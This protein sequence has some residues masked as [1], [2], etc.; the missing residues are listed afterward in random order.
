[1]S[2]LFGGGVDQSAPAASSLQLQTSN[3]GRAITIVYGTTRIS[4]NLIWY[5][6]FKSIPQTQ[7]IG[8]KGGSPTQTTYTY[9]VAA[10][11]ALCEGVLGSITEKTTKQWSYRG[12][13]GPTTYTYTGVR[14]IYADQSKFTPATLNMS[15]FTGT[16]AQT[17]F[18]YVTTNHP[19]E[20]LNYKNLAYVASGAY[21]L[22][23]NSSLPQHL[24]EVIG[25]LANA[26]NTGIYDA[27]PYDIAYD[28]LTNTVY[29]AS[30]PSGKLADATGNYL[31]AAGIWLSPSYDTPAP[32]ADALKQIAML[33]NC[34]WVWSGGVLR[35][36]PYGLDAITGGPGVTLAQGSTP[37]G[38]LTYTP[39]SIATPVY[40]L[41]DGDFLDQGGDD[42]VIVTRSPQTFAYN[43]VQVKYRNRFADYADT[44]AEAKDLASIEAFGLLPMPDVSAPEICDGIVARTVA[45]M[46]L[47]RAQ[48]IR[49]TYKF[50]VGYRYILLDP[51]DLVTLTESTGSGLNNQV[52]RITQITENDDGSL[53]IEAEDVVGNVTTVA[54]YPE[55][56][57]SGYLVNY[58]DPAP[59]VNAPIIFD[60]PGRKT[61]TGYELWIAV[62]Q[63]ASPWG[64]CNVWVSLD[65]STYKMVGSQRGSARY[66]T[67]TSSV[68]AGADPD[69]VNSIPVDLTTSGGTLTA[70]STSDADNANTLCWLDGELISYSAATL[71]AANKYT[72][73][74]Y[75]R[76]GVY[77]TTIKAHSNG[78]G[79][80]RLDTGIFAYPYDPSLVGKTV[81]V[82]LQSVNS[83]GA[84]VQDISTCTPYSYTI[85]GPIG[86]P[87]AA[88][89]LTAVA[90]I[91]G[92]QL[93]W[94]ASPSPDLAEYEI[95]SGTTW[96]SATYIGRSRTTSYLLPPPV[97]GTS[98]WLVAAMNKAGAYSPAISVTLTVS[99]PS[100][101]TVTAQVVDNTVLL[102]WTASTGTLPVA[103]YQ[104]RKGATYAGATIIGTKSG[105]FTTV[106][107][108]A[109]G[110]YTYWV[111]AIDG[112]GNFG[113][114]ASVTTVVNQPPDYVL[115]ALLTSTFT[116]TKTNAV[117]DING[118][119]VLPVDTTTQ[120]QTHFTGNSWA[121]PQDQVTAG[122]TLFIEPASATGSYVEVFDLGAVI[123]AAKITVAWAETD[124]GTPGVSCVIATSPDNI[125]YTPFGAGT[126]VY[127]TNYRYVKVTLS[128]TSSAGLDL[129]TIS[130][131]T[132]RVDAKLKNDAGSGTVTVAASGASVSFGASFAAVTSITVTPA[133]TSGAGS[134]IIPVVSFAGGANPT[135]FTVY[136][137]TTAGA[138]TTGSFNWSAKGY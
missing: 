79:F 96:A 1:M 14:T 108:T 17:A 54:Q 72:L 5:S 53:D 37:L 50:R 60:A 116:G 13:S 23:S 137:Y 118:T 88:S 119:L 111:V 28:L 52:V 63:P 55:Q 2:G 99:A 87:A 34:E 61:A 27:R 84:G 9:Q 8:G 67:L 75:I 46:L 32:V 89:A 102:F 15:V 73:G 100:A 74:T 115:K 101:P 41:T 62:G 26:G 48:Y 110:T 21:N 98:S 124:V 69:T 68:A 82:K 120:Y 25:I 78:A 30:W 94:T 56:L 106:Q 18:S 20:A 103:T 7:S 3:Y 38:T 33:S 70:G 86:A 44:V 112:A 65:G 66:G 131:L 51:M 130:N 90:A 80:A 95:R 49:N 135:S 35:F 105:L 31:Y 64:G 10:I 83:W 47:Q 76:R 4:G 91:G 57:P 114:P 138:L 129:A 109:A 132:V 117:V 40:A 42:P 136:L 6:D 93:S 104:I 122:K 81:Y 12:Y 43:Q 125:T 127:G 36:I 107:E 77:G 128:A 29:G 113:T 85:Q 97:A 19:T 22:G 45:Q 58:N 126:A 16:A 39:G 24:F 123:A 71:T 11:L 121:S 133:V 92:V 59:A 134:A